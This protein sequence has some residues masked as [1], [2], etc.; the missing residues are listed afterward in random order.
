[1]GEALLD[2][3]QARHRV[4][5]D[6]RPLLGRLNDGIVQMGSGL[7]EST[8]AH[9]RNIDVYMARLIE[10]MIAGREE[11]VRQIR[12]DIKLLARTIAAVAEEPDR[13]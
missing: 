12:S 10:E 3:G 6:L 11:T 9:I 7:D 13:A 5:R 8:R 2:P 4:E 1:M